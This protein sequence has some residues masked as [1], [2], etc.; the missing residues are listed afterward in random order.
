MTSA[1][2]CCIKIPPRWLG[3]ADRQF[4]MTHATQLH[5]V[6]VAITQWLW[7]LH[8][9]MTATDALTTVWIPPHYGMPMSWFG[10]SAGINVWWGLIPKDPPYRCSRE[11]ELIVLC[12]NASPLGNGALIQGAW[13]MP[14]WVACR[15]GDWVERILPAWLW[16]WVFVLQVFVGSYYTQ[17]TSPHQ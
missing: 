9:L 5:T 3:S 15:M 12:H 10:F 1:C 11:Q 2:S 13:F 4:L 14:F 6:F 8:R 7:P 16:T 17:C